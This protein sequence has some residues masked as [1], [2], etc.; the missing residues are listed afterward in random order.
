M[1]EIIC[2]TGPIDVLDLI[3]PAIQ[4]KG[5]PFS[6]VFKPTTDTKG[7]WKDEKFPK[8]W[9]PY[10]NGREAI[11][12]IKSKF[13]VYYLESRVAL[14]IDNVTA[15][16][17]YRDHKMIVEKIGNKFIAEMQKANGI[18]ELYQQIASRGLNLTIYSDTTFSSKPNP[19][20]II[21]TKNFIALEDGIK[22]S[23]AQICSDNITKHP[24]SDF[25]M[26]NIANKENLLGLAVC[27]L[28]RLE[29]VGVDEDVVTHKGEPIH[30]QKPLYNDKKY[31]KRNIANTT[32][33]FSCRSLKCN[34]S[35][36]FYYYDE[37]L[38]DDVVIIPLKEP[39]LLLGDFV[40]KRDSQLK[41]L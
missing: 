33:G 11:K 30:Y 13:S 27:I 12:N 1:K 5:E 6:L 18:D 14:E 15:T 22:F 36:Y 38:N 40:A 8:E 21:L 10:T 37:N 25:G 39:F 3:Y 9:L 35:D 28:D 26:T 17:I 24:Y 4:N 2:S 23:S 32:D 7:K 29:K 31:G 41:S 19:F 34:T 20:T 16:K